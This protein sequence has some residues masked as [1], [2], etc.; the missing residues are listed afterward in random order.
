[1]RSAEEKCWCTAF[2]LLTCFITVEKVYCWAT[3]HMTQSNASKSSVFFEIS[4]LRG[5]LPCRHPRSLAL[6]KTSFVPMKKNNIIV[7]RKIWRTQIR[8]N[9]QHH[10]PLFGFLHIQKESPPTWHPVRRI[11]GC[12]RRATR[13]DGKL[14][15][16]HT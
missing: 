7:D 13:L 9:N 5:K 4:K 11:F 15:M 6:D 1:M 3:S 2:T 12:S 8:M 14:E 10:P 16:R